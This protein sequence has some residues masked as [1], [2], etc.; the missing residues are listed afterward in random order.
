MTA[1]MEVFV[2]EE[3]TAMVDDHEEW[4][5]CGRSTFRLDQQV[6]GTQCT[7]AVRGQKILIKFPD[8]Q[9][10]HF[11]EIGVHGSSPGI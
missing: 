7:N 2:S 11:C 1:T 8:L 4:H 10:L 6:I 5:L 9:L 3:V